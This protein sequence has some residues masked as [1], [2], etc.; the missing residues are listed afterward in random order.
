MTTV[1][2]VLGEQLTANRSSAA[3]RGSFAGHRA[4]VT[5]LCER[6][7]EPGGELSLC[8]L[9][10]G[11]ANDLE[12]ERLARRYRSI[13]LVDLDADAL[14]GAV[15]RESP[16]TQARLVCHAP[17]DVS[18]LLGRLERWR[19]MECTAEELARRPSEVSAELAAK[20]GAFDVVVSA[21]LLTQMQRAVV[22]VL[23]DDHRLFEAVRFTLTLSH[24]RTLAALTKPGGRM[25]LVS[26]LSATDIA[27]S[28]ATAADAELPALVSALV[29][30]GQVFQVAQ[31]DL[32]RR[33]TREDPLLATQIVT[34]PACEAWRW[35]NGSAQTFLVYAL[36][37]RRLR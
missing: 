1:R 33:M 31:P 22:S 15:A 36:E 19:R 26:D 27:P 25:L 20:L 5:E 24:L 6:G 29:T 28:I 16:A 11:N 35:Q 3:E 32:L 17:L 8:V 34:S 9:G 7:A 4:R 2:E 23:G 12:L 37:A 13:H 10:A 21:C 18:G 14:A 30:R